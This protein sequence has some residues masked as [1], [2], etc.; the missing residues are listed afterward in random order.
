M[1][2]DTKNLPKSKIE[3]SVE[4]STS[5]MEPYLD[6]AAADLSKDLKV[7]GFRPGKAPRQT[8]EQSLGKEKVYQEGIERAIRESYVKIILEK[9]LE[10]LGKPQIQVT[11]GGPGQPLVYRATLEIL[12]EIKLGK[13]KNLKIEKKEVKVDEKEVEGTLKSIQNSRVKL[14]TVKRPA[15]KGDRVEVDFETRLAGAKIDG[16]E[17]KNHPLVIGQGYFVP[18]FEDKLIGM[19]EGDEKEFNLTFPGD[20]YKKELAGKN[21]D[22]KVKMKLVQERE[23]PQVD[24]QFAKSLGKFDNLVSLK[25]SVKDGIKQ[26]KEMKE[27]E[28][29]R[30][31]LIEKVVENSQMEIPRILIDM[32]IEKM[33][34]EFENSISQTGLTLDQYLERIKKTRQN[35]EKDWQGQA[36]KRV[37]VAL[38]LREIAK[39]EN[40]TVSQKEVE[41]ETNKALAHLPTGVNVDQI[42]QYA[43]GIL[44]NEK[45]FQLL[46]QSAITS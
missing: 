37:Q 26:E 30:A 44:T 36:K 24:D 28:R 25:K 33:F 40:V 34:K 42:K 29:Q 10:V 14:V 27:K 5:E 31:Q 43:R 7:K 6:K 18:G 39:K 35:L 4:I 45:V 16:G 22:F 32:E 12:P 8:V 46:E 13:Y 3:L 41:E 38:A 19:K 23:L 2:V 20:Y 1:K 15:K 17:S 21:V 11:K 9:K